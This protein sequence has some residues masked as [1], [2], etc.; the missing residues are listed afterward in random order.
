MADVSKGSSFG[1][2]LK[3]IVATSNLVAGLAATI[4]GT[5]LGGDFSAR[6]IGENILIL[7]APTMVGCA[8]GNL[9]DVEAMKYSEGGKPTS[10][11]GDVIT[12]LAAGST[13]ALVLLAAGQLDLG[14]NQET[15]VTILIAG[16]SC[17]LGDLV[18]H[19]LL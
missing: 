10:T 3:K 9:V 5:A 1:G 17:M 7:G 4:I 15:I 19:D 12:A 13:A 8:V 16:G 18:A 14:A 11:T 6:S 2:V